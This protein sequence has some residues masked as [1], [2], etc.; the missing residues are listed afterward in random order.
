MAIKKLVEVWDGKDLIVKNICFLKQKTNEKNLKQEFD[1]MQSINQPTPPI[2]INNPLIRSGLAFANANLGVK[3]I[4]QAD[5]TDGILT[6]LEVLSLDLIGTELVT[7]SACDTG[8]GDIKN[9]E[10]VYSL[11][12][13]FQEAGAKAVLSTLWKVD[14]EATSEFMQNFYNRFLE[15]IPAQQAIQ[16]TQATQLE[17]M[18]NEKYYDPFYW[19]GFVMTGKE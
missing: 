8:I 11:N 15:G 7:L 5:D 4:K 10:G 13:A 19:A 12:R 14:D 3:G 18:Q 2:K 6:A 1:L 9:G 16:A 17:F